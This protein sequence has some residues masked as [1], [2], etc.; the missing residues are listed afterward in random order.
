MFKKLNT[1]LSRGEDVNIKHALN[2][3]VTLNNQFSGGTGRIVAFYLSDDNYSQGLA[4]LDFLNIVPND[5][6]RNDIDTEFL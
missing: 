5:A 6:D 3:A 2:L 4:I 1:Q